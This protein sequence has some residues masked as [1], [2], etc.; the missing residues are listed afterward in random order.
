MT[1]HKAL[2]DAAAN[3][4]QLLSAAVEFHRAGELPKADALY[5]RVVRINRRNHEALH[6]W[7]LVKQAQGQNRDALQLLDRA[8]HVNPNVPSAH[9]HRGY[10]LQDLGRRKEAIA[11]LS[12]AIR[13]QPDF[14][15]AHIALGTLHA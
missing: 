13:L 14:I 1:D 5:G 4:R 2:A 11:S 7:A 3:E 12:R 15:D 9:C 6:R 8:I 10:V